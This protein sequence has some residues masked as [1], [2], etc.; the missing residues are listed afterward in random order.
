MPHMLKGPPEV[1]GNVWLSC[2]RASESQRWVGP[3]SAM[4][5]VGG[6]KTLFHRLPACPHSPFISGVFYS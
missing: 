2:V 4:G 1:V 3:N 5:G 6:L